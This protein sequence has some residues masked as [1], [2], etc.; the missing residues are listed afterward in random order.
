MS[1]PFIEH[2]VWLHST[3]VAWAARARGRNAKVW[4]AQQAGDPLGACAELLAQAPRG[5]VRVLDRAKVLLG[6][7][8]VHY[9]M[10]P[11][12]TDLYSAGD[13][14]GFAEATFNQQAG[15]DPERWQV[16]VAASQF[17]DE[18]LAVAAPRDLLHDLRELFKLQRLPLVTCAPL[19]T[20]VAQQYWRQLPADCVLAVP[21]A[22]SLSCLYR[23][24]GRADQVC[25]ISTQPG[26]T[27]SDNLFTADLLAQRQA[28]AT[29]VVANSPTEHWLGPLHP[30]LGA[31]LP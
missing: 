7:P 28:P 24:Q 15:I 27:L 22:E 6:F 8:H 20:A 1:F 21:E 5:R 19:L 11:W 30:W 31:P 9:L 25:V 3:G 16:Q 17:G 29:R 26:S 23:H 12:Q 4:G 10:L 18:R 14:Q 13:W 2:V